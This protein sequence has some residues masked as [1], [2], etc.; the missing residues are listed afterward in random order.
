MPIWNPIK[1]F[2]PVFGP[3]HFPLKL[4]FHM[5]CLEFKM[6]TLMLF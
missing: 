2:Y 3:E 5:N 4:V 6:V 1:G